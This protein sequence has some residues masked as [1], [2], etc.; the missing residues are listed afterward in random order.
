MS[1]EGGLNFFTL[2]YFLADDSVEIK[3]I[4]RHNNGKDPFSL[5]LN[6]KKL[7]KVKKKN[8]TKYILF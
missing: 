1:M 8:Q 4:R 5:F 3:E 7:P 6:R 2:N